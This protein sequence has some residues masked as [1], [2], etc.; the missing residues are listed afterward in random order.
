MFT[1]VMLTNLTEKMKVST[2]LTYITEVYIM[3]HGTVCVCAHER[4][5][6][7]YGAVCVGVRL[8]VCVCVCVCVCGCIHV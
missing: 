3:K 6:A 2:Y 4:E 7:V 8:C 1:I 5:L